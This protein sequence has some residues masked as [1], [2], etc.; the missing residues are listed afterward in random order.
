MKRYSI[1][2]GLFFQPDGV[3]PTGNA[4]GSQQQSQNTTPDPFA[5]IDFDMLDESTRT[6]LTAAKDQ[7][8]MVAKTV[9]QK[10]QELA[11]ARG[12]QSEADRRLAE[13]QRG[14]QQQP[15]QQQQAAPTL[16]QELT[17][18]Y[19]DEG[20]EP[21]AAARAAKIQ[22]KVLSRF[23]GKLKA[24]IGRDLQPM[25]ATVGVQQA[26][27]A[28]AE[29][30]QNDRLGAFNIPEISQKVWETAQGDVG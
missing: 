2:C 16:E 9:A 13:F 8:A 3:T 28:F 6:K 22:A 14:N 12:A 1:R 27:S 20:L 29:A 30:Q 18:T 15:Q 10:E 4:E 24:E 26:A 17:Q 23:E 19:I 25:A 7:F 5:G 11:T 21:S